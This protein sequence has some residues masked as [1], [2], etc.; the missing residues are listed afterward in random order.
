[1]I[2][3]QHHER[4]DDGGGYPFGIKG[5]DIHPYAAICCL[6]DIYDALTGKRSY[7]EGK[8]PAVALEIMTKEC[9]VTLTKIC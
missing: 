4:D 2:V 8:P 9:L 1:M 3:I 6:A 7:K 5:Y